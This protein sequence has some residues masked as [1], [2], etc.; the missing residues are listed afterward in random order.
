M[1][2]GTTKKDMMERFKLYGEIYC[3][4]AGI[5]EDGETDYFEIPDYKIAETLGEEVDLM[6]DCE[7]GYSGSFE[8]IS[9]ESEM[10]MVW[11]FIEGEDCFAFPIIA[12]S[13]DSIRKLK[14]VLERYVEVLKEGGEK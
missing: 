6:L 7:N 13:T 12:I 11:C 9:F 14:D 1:D 4:L 2:L 5:I 8:K 3:L 10:I